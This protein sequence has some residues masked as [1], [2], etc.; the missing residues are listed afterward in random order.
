VAWYLALSATIGTK[1][2]CVL[3]LSF[4]RIV[5]IPSKPS[6]SNMIR[7]KLYIVANEDNKWFIVL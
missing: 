5:V 2:L 1:E 3:V 6:R 7:L 4:G